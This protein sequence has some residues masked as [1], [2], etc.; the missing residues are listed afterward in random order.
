MPKTVEKNREA[1]R[2]FRKNNPDGAAAI[3]KKYSLSKPQKVASLK[4]RWQQ[5][6]PEK[7]AIANRLSKYGL[8]NEVYKQLLNEQAGVC[9]TCG[10]LGKVGL[11]VDH[12]H[13][14]GKVRG[15]L[16]REC[17]AALG[18]IKDDVRTLSNMINYLKESHDR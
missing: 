2:R 11:V 16:C 12:D 14:T 7:Q 9:K 6:N 5:A 17:N 3:N 8:S 4:K 13:T 10:G 1:V 15:V 18:F